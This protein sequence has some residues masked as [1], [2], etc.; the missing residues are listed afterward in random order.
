MGAENTKELQEDGQKEVCDLV[1][2]E[3]VVEE[4]TLKPNG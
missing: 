3:L 4:G 1:P 2:S